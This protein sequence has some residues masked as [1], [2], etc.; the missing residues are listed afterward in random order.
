MSEYTIPVLKPGWP[1]VIGDLRVVQTNLH[2]PHVGDKLVGEQI[3]SFQ[4]PSIRNTHQEGEELE[5][6][7]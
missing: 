2:Y 6:F 1:K 5:I 3:Y 7:F 4:H